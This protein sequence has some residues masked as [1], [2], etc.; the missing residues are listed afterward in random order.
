MIHSGKSTLGGA[1][2]GLYNYEGS[3]KL[4]GVELKDVRKYVGNGIIS[5]APSQTEIFNDTLRY[6]IA[7]EDNDVT[8]EL[9]IS[10]LDKDINSFASKEDEVLSHSNSN[11]SGGQL[12]RLQIARGIYDKPKLIIMDDPFNAIDIDMSQKITD[13]IKKYC[14]ESILVLINNQKEILQKMDKIIFLKHGSYLYG[15][16]DELLKDKDFSELVGGNK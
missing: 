9:K 14:N 12:K 7:F 11:L 6:N 16:Y 13:N 8:N 2:S 4:Q 1:L 3:I 10:M 5:Y 15:T